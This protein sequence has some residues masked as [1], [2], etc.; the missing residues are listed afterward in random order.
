MQGTVFSPIK[1][2]VVWM[3]EDSGL[4]VTLIETVQGVVRLIKAATAGS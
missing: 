1:L 2:L 3:D 4:V